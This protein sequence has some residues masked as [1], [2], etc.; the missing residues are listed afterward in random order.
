M[1]ASSEKESTYDMTTERVMKERGG[2]E[3]VKF[4]LNALRL[5]SC[6]QAGHHE[7]GANRKADPST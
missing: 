7:E 3:Q 1:Q 6:G 5:G 2:S 4:C